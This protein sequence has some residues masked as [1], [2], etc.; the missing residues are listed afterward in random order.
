MGNNG[1]VREKRSASIVESFSIIA[2]MFIVMFY[3][4]L[5]GINVC[6]CM[7][8]IVSY[9]LLI[10]WRCGYNWTEMFGAMIEKNKTVIGLFFIMYGIGFLLSTWMY[11]GTIPSL[12]YYLLHII[13]AKW[14]ILFA[15]V[16]CGIISV[17]IGTSFGTCGTVG[18]VMMGVGTVLDVNLAILAAAVVAGSNLG[19]AISPMSDILNLTA[20]MGKV[21]PMKAVKRAIYIVA[22][23]IVISVIVYTVI[24]ITSGTSGS[25]NNSEIYVAIDS[26]FNVNIASL[27][28]F[29]ILLIGY[30]LKIDTVICLFGSGIVAII[31]GV[32]LNGFD[33][34]YG[35]VCGYSG[36]QLAGIGVDSTKVMP[37]LVTLCE[38]GGITSMF[39]CVAVCMFAL[40]FAGVVDKLG[41]LN[42]VVNT[43]F[44]KAKSRVAVTTCEVVTGWVCACASANSYF[45]LL[46]PIEL[47]KNRAEGAG[48]TP[49]DLSTVSNTIGCLGLSIIPW[50]T[51]GVYMSTCVGVSCAEFAPYCIF[52]WGASVMAII[53]S[54]FGFGYNKKAS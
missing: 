26:L 9:V 43:I 7:V 12:I 52:I 28:P 21:E 10:G 6:C 48:I 23:V 53:C 31:T 39:S 15:F 25:V 17:I 5:T 4:M 34:S 33:F 19:Q 24:G 13:N 46:T 18:V 50:T 30:I 20:A 37:V 3:G 54:V 27:L 49:I 1:T 11:S 44:V 8:V 47:F 32:L 42:T 16:I 35:F 51:V 14:C 45:T 41:A 29:V 2:V 36:F 22:P 40:S 38:R